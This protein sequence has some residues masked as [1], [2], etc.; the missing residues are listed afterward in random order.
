MNA[1]SIK[2]SFVNTVTVD[3]TLSFRVCVCLSF[4]LIVKRECESAKRTAIFTMLVL[5][6]EDTPYPDTD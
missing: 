2:Q 6:E 4:V 1:L 3:S 5:S